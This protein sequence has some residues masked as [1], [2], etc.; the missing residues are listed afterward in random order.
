MR[1]PTAREGKA[2]AL[3][4]RPHGSNHDARPPTRR[5]SANPPRPFRFCVNAT[6][7]ISDTQYLDAGQFGAYVRLLL[8]YWRSGPPQDD[9]RLLS[10][11]AGMSP[12][13]WSATRSALEPFF[14]IEGGRWMH[15]RTDEDLAAAYEAIN[16]ASRAGKI[17]AEAR[18]GK[19]RACDRIADRNP[20][21]SAADDADRNAGGSAGGIAD[22]PPNRTAMRP[23][24]ES[25]FQQE[26]RGTAPYDPLPSQADEMVFMGAESADQWSDFTHDPDEDGGAA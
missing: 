10:R 23:H 6:D 22:E 13:E 8:A 26:Y 21:R 20:A 12:D 4:P 16:K 3:D 5:R 7:L 19:S 15:W 17:A 24:Y 25:Q 14:D 18:W 11:I 1:T 9:D 2:G